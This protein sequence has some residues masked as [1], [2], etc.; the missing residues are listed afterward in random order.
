[1]PKRRLTHAQRKRHQEAA[2][3]ILRNRENGSSSEQDEAFKAWLQQDPENE[4]AYAAAEMLLGDAR[5]AI[6]SDPDLNSFEA[7]PANSRKLAG[8]S[9]LT[10]ALVGGLFLYFDGPVRL[11]A[12]AYSGVA[13][14]PVIELEDGSTI[15]LNASSAVAFDYSEQGRTVRLLKGEAL[16]EVAKDPTRPF[17]VEAGDT[18]VTAL[19]TAFDIRLGSDET[20]VT[21][22]HNAVLVEFEDPQISPVRL[23]EGERISYDVNGRLSEVTKADANAVLAWQSGLLV[24]DNAPLSY[25]IEELE[26]R[27]Y[28][29]IVVANEDLANR[30]ISGT[31]SISDTYAALAYIEQALNL[32]ATTIGPLVIIRD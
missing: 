14:L 23:Q 28:G 11:Q 9:L 8:G 3:W 7:R 4:R 13:E 6:E 16:F 27:F 5:K 32:N 26:R 20:D 17:T 15:H 21:V 22:T 29:R 12:D 1:M 18:V 10:V 25:V 30:K 31:I 24:L 2:D 19:G